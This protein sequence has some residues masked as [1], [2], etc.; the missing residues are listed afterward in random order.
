VIVRPVRRQLP[1][2]PRRGSRRPS[3]GGP[4]AGPLRPSPGGLRQ[5]VTAPSEALDTSFAYFASTP[6]PVCAG[7]R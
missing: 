7:G 2:G 4:S 1:G 3:N 6:F 5:R